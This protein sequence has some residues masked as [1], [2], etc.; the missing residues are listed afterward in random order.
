MKQI[1]RYSEYMSF[2]IISTIEIRV[3]CYVEGLELLPEAYPA[4]IF[5]I[6][7]YPQLL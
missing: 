1:A 5:D 4:N 3:I 7:S 6:I 2:D